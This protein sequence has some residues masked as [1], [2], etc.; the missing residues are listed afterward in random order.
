MCQVSEELALACELSQD[1]VRLIKERQGSA[2]K[3]WLR[4]ANGSTI[5]ELK[6]IAK[7]IQQDYAAIEAACSQAWSQGQV[8]RQ[9]NRLKC[10]KRQLYGRTRF[11]LLPL[12]VLSGA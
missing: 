7:S 8:E 10:V 11:D 9:I 2:L 1:F 4:R 12:R 6:S 5:S 3:D